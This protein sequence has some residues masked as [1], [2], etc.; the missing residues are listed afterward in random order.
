[1][2]QFK[3]IAIFYVK[4]TEFY[5]VVHKIPIL[6]KTLHMHNSNPSCKQ[7]LESDN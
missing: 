1:M 5:E 3:N 6:N 7:S 4:H 2:I